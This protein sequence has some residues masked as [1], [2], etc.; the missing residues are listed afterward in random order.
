MMLPAFRQ[1]WSD[2]G[3]MMKHSASTRRLVEANDSLQPR[4]ANADAAPVF[5]DDLCLAFAQLC[6]R[7]KRPYSKAQIRAAA[8]PSP[9]GS[10]SGTVHLA[11]ERLGFNVRSIK[12]SKQDLAA[13]APPFLLVG[14]RPGQGWLVTARRNDHL[15][16]QNP[17]RGGGAYHDIET[18]LDLA[19]EILLLKPLAA[20]GK[21]PDWRTPIFRRLKPILWELGLA[22]VVINLVA[23]GTPIFLMTVYNKVIN[24][25]ALQTLDVLAFGMLTLFAF[26]WLLRCLRSYIT[27]H[28]G[29]RLD[30][31]LGGEVVH[32][33]VHQPLKHFDNIPAGQIMERLRQLDQLRSFV[34]SQLPL[35]LVD[36]SFAAVFLAVLYFLDWRLGAIT[37]AAIPLFLLLSF[38]ANGKHQQRTDASHQAAAAKASS[39]AETI[40]HAITVKA[41]GLEPEME[42]RF[43]Q[44]LAHA[45]ETS[46][47]ASHL[48]GLINN[49]GQVLQHLVA[50]LIVYFGARAIIAG[51]MSIGAL[52]AATILAARTLAPMRQVV[53]GWQQLQSIRGAF[54]RLDQ[55][56]RQ[57]TELM[58]LPM[59]AVKVQG[60]IRFED[61]V[62]RYAP[63]TGPVLNKIDID[64]GPGEI[65]GVVGPSGSGKSTLAKLLLGLDRPE[66]G[67]ILIDDTDT[68]LWSPTALRQQIG[69]VPQDVQL[70]AGSIADNIKLGAPEQGYDR[71]VAAA[72]FVGANDFIQRLPDGYDTELS[73]RGGGLSAGQRQLITIARALIRNPPILILDEATSALDKACEEALLLGLKCASRGRTVIM[74]THRLAGLA[75][76]DRVLTMAEGQVLEEGPALPWD[77]RPTRTAEQTDSSIRPLL[78]PV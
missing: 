38:A 46:F 43:K 59:L 42:Q 72:K 18:V 24:H 58:D 53:T 77:K 47:R 30:A 14:K 76:A 12:V 23:L 20:S 17:E 63:G 33:L 37:T 70:F 64:I 6:A 62:Y 40:S 22:S 4:A 56:M 16:L 54:D 67:R 66:Q 49:S 44:R 71:I 51:D 8:P 61:V 34:T 55:L 52:V 11:A 68:R 36:L 78:R 26:D 21:A 3:N 2:G 1:L 25:G 35:L 65:I 15:E 74:V 32:H 19:G 28:A 41:L 31:A 13:A 7:L 75:V 69:F 39:L 5:P 48:D 10:T 60:R 45:A 27:S 50:L 73:E 57:P 9:K 29:G